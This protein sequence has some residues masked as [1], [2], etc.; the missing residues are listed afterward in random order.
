[1]GKKFYLSKTFW[2]NVIA[3]VGLVVFN[4]ETFIADNPEMIGGVLVVLNLI[5]RAI[6]KEPLNWT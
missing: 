2:I 1:M 4:K 3:M 5:L 6:T